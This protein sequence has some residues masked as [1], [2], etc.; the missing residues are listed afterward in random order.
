MNEAFGNP[1]TSTEQ[2]LH[3]QK[4]VSGEG[5]VAVS[6]PDVADA[7]GEDWEE[8][9]SDVMGEFFLRTYLETRTAEPAAALAAAGWG[10]DRYALLRGPGDEYALVSLI[11]WDTGQDAREFLNAMTSTGSVSDEDFLDLNGTRMLWVVSP[12]GDVVEEIRSLWPEF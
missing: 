1:P 7:L 6:L 4:Y 2:V 5:P 10:G 9:Y 11:E 12:S 3:P 8:V